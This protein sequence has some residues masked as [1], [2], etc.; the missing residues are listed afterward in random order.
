[1]ADKGHRAGRFLTRPGAPPGKL[2]IFLLAARLPESRTI[3]NHTQ[4]TVLCDALAH[5][6]TGAGHATKFRKANRTSH[7]KAG[8]RR[9]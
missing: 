1:M 5:E 3:D 2:K 6:I 9:P 4:T 8:E 7:H